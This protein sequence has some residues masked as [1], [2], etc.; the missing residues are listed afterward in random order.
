[1]E[2]MDLNPPSFSNFGIET[3]MEMGNSQLVADLIA[4]E[5]ATASPD[6][7][8]DINEEPKKEVKKPQ[9]PKKVEKKPETE[10]EDDDQPSPEE[11]IIK[12]LYGEEE[13]EE[14]PVDKPVKKETDEDEDVPK[15]NQ[16]EAIAKDLFDLGVLTKDEEEGDEVKI[17]TPEALL[18]RFNHEKKKGAIKIVDDFIGQFGED[19]QEA[20][21]A[22]YVKGVD[23]REYFAT[24]NNIKNYAELDLSQE[25]NQISVVKEALSDQGLQ[26]EDL[27]SELE[28]IKNYGD[29]ESTAKRYHKA[30][31]KKEA[32]KLQQME[33]DKA[34]ELQ[35]RAA[36]KQQYAQNV[37]SILQEKIKSK[38]FDGIPINPKLATE[39]Q[40][41]LTTDKYKTASGEKL[42]DFDKYILD[43][44]KPENHAKKV[45]LALLLKVIEKDPTLAT[46]QKSGVTK[47]TDQ[48]FSE[49]V[50]QKKTSAKTEQKPTSWWP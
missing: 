13:E 7:V 22:I 21:Q 4:P 18:E 9:P 49:V 35:V 14:E 17:E 46:I 24:Y 10:E 26:G 19:Y 23:P 47:K 38:E 29:L 15:V 45:K 20:F 28:R 16:F 50:R 1:M 3:T 48:L 11:S 44:K 30:L 27:A 12:G 41:F 32:T 25:I 33:Q 34:E 36:Q 5:T 2:N 6:K 31:V 8:T 39:L 43:L 42:T 40:D 37:N